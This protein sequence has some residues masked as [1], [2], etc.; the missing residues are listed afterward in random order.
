[1]TS[2]MISYRKYQEDVRHNREMERL[3]GEQQAEAAR[4]NVALEEENVRTNKANERIKSSQNVITAA[5]YTTMDAETNRHN[6]EVEYYTWEQPILI[7]KQR[8]DIAHTDSDTVKNY[9]SA[10]KD[11]AAVKEILTLLDPKARQIEA[12]ILGSTSA[13]VRDTA[14]AL[15]S[16][17]AADL[18]KT[19]GLESL[20]KTIS[21]LTQSA[22]N[23]L[24]SGSDMIKAVTLFTN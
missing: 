19:K 10:A 23:I 4:H 2:N 13:S 24:R 15:Q 5:H 8:S 3:T 14:S 12:S 20:S 7:G 22:G 11:K 16:L 9:A 6:A 18:N 21:N 1:M 17:T